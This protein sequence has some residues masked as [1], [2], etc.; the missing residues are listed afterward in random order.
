MNGDGPVHKVVFWDPRDGS[1]LESPRPLDHPGPVT[2]AAFAGP[3]RVLTA[4]RD[5]NLY[6]WDVRAGRVARTVRGHLDAVRG[7]ALAADGSALFSAGDR[8]AK[9]WPAP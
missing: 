3:G 6:L 5:G 7:L 9:R 4:A 1:A 2:A 8:S